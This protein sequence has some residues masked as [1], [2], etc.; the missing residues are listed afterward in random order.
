M[1]WQ[2]H[3][4]T[5]IWVHPETKCI[6]FGEDMPEE[7]KPEPGTTLTLIDVLP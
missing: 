5:D 7:L 3:A 4:L 6:I 2:W 1:E